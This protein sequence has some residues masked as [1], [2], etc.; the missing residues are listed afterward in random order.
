MRIPK[1][2]EVGYVFEVDLDYPESFRDLHNDY[3]L[4]PEKITVKSNMLSPTAKK[5]LEEIGE[6]KFHEA[7][8]LI[9][10]LM[11]KLNYITYYQN[12]Y[13]I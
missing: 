7:E 10:N 2:G 1:E 13:F 3:S 6:T 5:I 11:N 12:Q 4:A 9:P 8:K